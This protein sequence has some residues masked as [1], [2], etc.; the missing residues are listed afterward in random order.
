MGPFLLLLFRDL[1]YSHP[2]N[3]SE[4]VASKKTLK[5][6]RRNIVPKSKLTVNADLRHLQI[7]QIVSSRS[8]EIHVYGSLTG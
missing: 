6:S 4:T 8:V 5:S 3:I 7:L 2:I 1:Q